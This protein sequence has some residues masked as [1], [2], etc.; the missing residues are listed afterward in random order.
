MA[1][2]EPHRKAYDG[3]TFFGCKKTLPK[4]NGDQMAGESGTN[5]LGGSSDGDDSSMV[6]LNDP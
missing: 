4:E 3:V 2:I 5:A 6:E 1:N